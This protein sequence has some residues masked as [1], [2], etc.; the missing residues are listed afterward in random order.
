M[1]KILSAV[2]LSLLVFTL[3]ACS[4][5]S[6]LSSCWADK[7][8][9]VY[10]ATDE[11]GTVLGSLTTVLERNPADKVIGEKTFSKASSRLTITYT[12]A[13][14]SFTVYSLLDGFVPLGSQKIYTNASD[15]SKNYTLTS[16]NDSKY[17]NYTIVKGGETDS[18][19]LRVKSPYIDNELIYVYLRCYDVAAVSLN[20]R[21]P[22]ALSKSVQEVNVSTLKKTTLKVNYGAETKDVECCEVYIKKADIPSGK[23]ITVYYAAD[24]EASTVYSDFN[25]LYHSKKYPVKIIENDIIYTM[26]SIS[27]VR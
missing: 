1:K 13:E 8:T 16:Y 15:E 6:T 17:Y 10:E 18:G 12:S 14:E 4:S 5:A 19:R 21:I 22:V 25:S 3:S 2:I 9:I 7:E 27:T 24:N 11:N 26:K 23:G 20:L